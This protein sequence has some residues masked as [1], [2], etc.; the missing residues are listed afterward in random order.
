MCQHEVLKMSGAL[1]YWTSMVQQETCF[2]SALDTL[3]QNFDINAAPSSQCY[4]FSKGVGGA[5]NNG[6]WNSYPH[7]EAGRRN[8]MQNLLAGIVAAFNDF[9]GHVNYDAYECTGDSVID[10]LLERANLKSVSQLDQSSIYSWPGF[11]ASLRT[12]IPGTPVVY[13]TQQ[14][15]QPTE[16]PTNAPANPTYRPT[17]PPINTGGDCSKYEKYAQCGG[18]GFAQLTG[19]QYD[20]CSMCP[21]GT[22][23]FVKSE[24]YSGC[25]EA[26]PNDWDCSQD[27][28]QAP[29]TTT[30]APETTTSEPEPTT[31]P[32][33]GACPNMEYDTC[34]G[35]GQVIG[36]GPNQWSGETC[37][38][39][40]YECVVQ[41]QWYSMCV[42]S[43]RMELRSFE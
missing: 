15:D 38:Q 27:A 37:C 42:S 16:D 24:W 12:F 10:T 2:A 18:E 33:P 1:Y 34:G 17:E 14:P 11:C 21:A 4:D 3:A 41:S 30:S 26:C 7:A 28:T 6:M 32:A 9:D 8:N 25:T 35:E 13:P 22:Q 19:S 29:E 23:C 31:A 39:E 36:S 5:I 40:G 43:R 20:G